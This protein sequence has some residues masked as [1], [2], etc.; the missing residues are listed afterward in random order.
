[1][2][3]QFPVSFFISSKP[4]AALHRPR[5][6]GLGPQSEGPDPPEHWGHI[7]G[8]L[9]NQSYEL[10]WPSVSLL[11]DR[12]PK[13]LH[14]CVFTSIM[15]RRLSSLWSYNKIRDFFYRPFYVFFNDVLVVSLFWFEW[16]DRVDELCR[17]IVDELSGLV[18]SV[19]VL[20]LFLTFV[21]FFSAAWRIFLV[22]CSLCL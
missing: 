2:P 21:W 13:K 4:L 15:D 12:K 8:L 1:M 19:V 6:K 10:L 16:N 14:S 20:I 5:D 17:S 11:V 3:Q 22:H 9:I 7:P 18:W